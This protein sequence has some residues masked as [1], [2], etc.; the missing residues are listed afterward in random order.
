MDL[1]KFQDKYGNRLMC[2]HPLCKYVKYFL[3][4]HAPSYVQLNYRIHG[5]HHAKMCLWT[6]DSEVPDRPATP[7]SLIRAFTIRLQNHWT[8]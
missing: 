4:I 1:F 2:R 5:P 3:H 7:C 8:V 6:A